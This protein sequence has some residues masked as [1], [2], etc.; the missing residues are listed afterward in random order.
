MNKTI[1]NFNK[2]GGILLF[3]AALFTSCTKDRGIV[4][5]RLP[6]TAGVYA[7]CEGS[8][9]ALNASTITYYDVASNVTT[10]DYFK[11]KNG[12]DLGSNANDLKQYGSKMYCVITGS[13]VGA[14]DSFVEVINIATGKSI[15]RIAFSDATKG[16]MPRHVEFYQGKAYVS[17][18][19]GFVTKIDTGSLNIE[20]RLPVGGA[21]DGVT[22]ANGKLYVANSLRDD[23]PNA[24]NAS[25]S[26]VD[27]NTFKKLKDIVVGTNPTKLAATVSGEVYVVTNGTYV[28]PFIAPSLERLNGVT[29]ARIQTYDYSL[30]KI[31]INGN[32]GL[33][34]AFGNYPAPDMVK[35]INLSTGALGADFIVDATLVASPYHITINPLDEDVYIADANN[36]GPEGKVIAFSTSGNSKFSFKT[37]AFPQSIVF[38]YK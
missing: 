22:V 36:Y 25:V 29:D 10:K 7:L 19:D 14:K 24:N 17:S 13:T 18:Y 3:G 16:F 35:L 37:G 27:L 38:N 1:T 30:N 9:G 5:E 2:L 15:K 34:I 12:I 4:A 33:V 6:T 11:L 32:K 20:S 23:F 8:F 28:A 21:L 26:V 31:A